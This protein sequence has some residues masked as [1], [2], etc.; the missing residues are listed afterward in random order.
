MNRKL[1]FVFFLIFFSIFFVLYAISTNAAPPPPTPPSNED[2]KEF[3][4]QALLDA[5]DGQREFVLGYLVN[6]VQVADILISQDETWGVVYLEMIDPETGQLLP[7]EPGLA[8]ARRVGSEWV[9]ILPSDPGWI[10]LVQAAPQDLLSDEY[11]ISYEEMYRT[12][13]LT[14]QAT[15][16][17]YLLPWEAGKKVYLSQSTG[18]DKYIP[19]GS[20]HYSFDFYI[21]KT[22]YQLRASKSGTVWRTRWDVP[23]GDDNDMG[24]YIVLKDTST[25]PT[26]YQLYLHLAE[27]SIPAGLRTQGANVTQGQFIGIADDTGQSTGHHLHFHVHTNPNSYWGTSVDITFDD[28]NI[29]GGRPRRESD[30]EYCTRPGD[31]CNQFRNFYISQNGAHG[32]TDPPIGDLF[33]PATGTLVSSSLLHVEGWSFDD[34]S[35]LNRTRLIANYDNEWHEVGAEISDIAFSM[36]WDMCTDD[37]PDGP[38]SI[39]L[40]IWDN[41][42]NPSQGLPGLTHVI[43]NFKC[44]STQPACTPGVNQI[45]IY[46]DSDYQGDC[47]LLD[48]G[49]YPELTVNFDNTIESIQVG[50]NVMAQ[51]FNDLNFDG[52]SEII[53]R[54]ES[55]LEDNPIGGDQ[56]SSLKVASR[57]NPPQPPADLL[58]PNKD[59]Q[60]PSGSS[61]TF[62]W[63]DSG[64]STQFQVSISGP[65][66]DT[67]SE[68]LSKPF[69][70][71]PGAQFPLGT[72]AWKVRARNCPDISCTSPWSNPSSFIITSPPPGTLSVSAPF[73]DDLE[74]GI[75]NWNFQGLWKRIN[76]PDRSHSSNHSWYYGLLPDHNYDTGGSNF[77]DLTSRPISIPDSNYVLRFWYRYDTEEGEVNWD[78]RRIQI[79]ADGGPF[80]NILQLKN[81]EP[82]RWHQATLDLSAYDD[83]TLQIRFHFATLDDQE[84][85]NH[86]GWLI[87]DIEIIQAN[88]PICSDADD[89]PAG[90]NALNF[91]QTIS[92]KICPTGDVDFFKFDGQAGD[93][94]VLD[95]DTPTNNPIPNLDLYLFLLDGDGQSIIA[96]HDD[97]ILGVIFDPRLGYHLT[98]SGT[99]YIRARLWSHPSH[100][101][102]EFS[103]DITLTKD[104]DNPQGS[105]ITPLSGSYLEDSQNLTLTVD[106]SDVK[107]GVSHIE[108]LFHPGDWLASDWQVIG[109]DQDG[110]DGWQINFDTTI[111]PEQKDI[112]FFANIYD[113]AG[114]WIGAGVWDIGL[115]RTPPSTTLSDLAPVQQSTAIHLQWSGTD[116]LSG[117]ESYN[118]QSQIGN[119]SWS[120]IQPK[121][122]GADESRWFIGQSGTQYGFRIRGVDYASNQESFPSNAEINTEIPNAATI[123][124]SPD[125]WDS[126][127][128]DNTPNSSTLINI[129]DSAQ[130]HNF[131]NP[132]T[133][134][135]L[136]DEDWVKFNVE[137][138]ETYVVESIPLSDM[139]GTILELYAANATTLLATAQ[140]NIL[141]ENVRIIWTS[142]RD[143]L[144]YL[145]VRHLDGNIAGNVVSYQL[146]VYRYSPVFLPIL[147]QK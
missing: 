7:S 128:N 130:T 64:G 96:Q 48:P 104:N 91:D 52:R 47:Q 35:G 54:D 140:S 32:D 8:I 41:A 135:R 126:S 74:S 18:H 132:L 4:E 82:N 69:W 95:I 19:S 24:N 17:G 22:M 20:A 121:P 139:T 60:F 66:G 93:H 89:S 119:G 57:T 85:N 146:M 30:L 3:I 99:Y 144:V 143:D 62:S 116:N 50:A 137:N 122:G 45:G 78:Q 111:L 28:V 134:N 106:A 23:N 83:Q 6:D 1:V 63:R 13:L 46:S 147:Q 138:R 70:N 44:G 120:N 71:L 61:L 29:N 110:S 53:G 65:N 115:D 112:A 107:S 105:F 21:H 55:D 43:K 103:Y 27:G 49:D 133:N 33:E 124:S 37:V 76:D 68:W 12:E 59:D 26:T 102:E 14:A 11:K 81:D 97:E 86:E 56:I 38:V 80:E 127:G 31:V 51:L 10:E 125:L 5:I 117:I 141:G 109:S 114:N 90:A 9:I 36:D 42:G 88:L 67:N 113:W 58:S 2:E 84:N 87:D 25:S 15:Y 39:A 145:R 108:F 16:S 79:S 131:C 101:G 100:G 75:G 123:C 98:R 142:D 72:Y 40:R 94:I 129:A 77:G 92:N 73:V 118:L 34:D 136:F